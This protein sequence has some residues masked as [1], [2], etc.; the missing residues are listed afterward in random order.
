MADARWILFDDKLSAA[1]TFFPFG[2]GVGTFVHVFPRFQSTSFSGTYV[3]NAHNDYLEWLMEGGL[4]ALVLL[5]AFAVFYVI[6]WA[7]LLRQHDWKTTQFI[8]VGAGIGVF[9]MI[10]HS[11]LDFN[12]HIP[13]NQIYF[14]FLAGLFFIESKEIHAPVNI[15]LPVETLPE[16]PVAE[17]KKLSFITENKNPFAD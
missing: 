2:S 13:A 12:L 10:L 4:V 11:F 7:K 14:A 17:V 1:L 3:N 8:Q 15:E 5:I 16:L 6:K 9:A